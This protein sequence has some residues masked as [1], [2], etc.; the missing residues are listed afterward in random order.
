MSKWYL[1]SGKTVKQITEDLKN[2]CGAELT[3]ERLIAH[4]QHELDSGLHKTEVMPADWNRCDSHEHV[5]TK[6]INLHQTSYNSTLLHQI[7][8]VL[9]FLFPQGMKPEDLTIELSLDAQHALRSDC[10]CTK[11]CMTCNITELF[12]VRVV[13]SDAVDF[14]RVVYKEGYLRSQ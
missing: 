10:P 4:A 12:G 6:G 9:R 2:A 8:E 3:S 5:L 14:A 1:I 11:L 7:D 13:Q